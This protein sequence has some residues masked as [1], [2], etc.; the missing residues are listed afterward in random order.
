MLL[1]VPGVTTTVPV[2]SASPLAG[3]LARLIDTD[4]VATEDEL[5]AEVEFWVLVCETLE[6]VKVGV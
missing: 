1:I 4:G 6:C 2:G 5:V 3:P